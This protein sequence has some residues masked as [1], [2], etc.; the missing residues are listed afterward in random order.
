VSSTDFTCR[1]RTSSAK[2]RTGQNATSSRLDGRFTA[3]AALMVNGSLLRFGSMP[4]AS[5]LK[6]N[7]GD[8]SSGMC[9]LRTS[10]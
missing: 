7:G 6:W 10:S 4:G 3:G 1:E 2:W 9:I 5:A 8:T